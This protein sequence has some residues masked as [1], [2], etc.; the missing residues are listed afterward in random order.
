MAAFL[1]VALFECSDS[2]CCIKET[3]E[4]VATCFSSNEAF[5]SCLSDVFSRIQAFQFLHHLPAAP[6][7]PVRRGVQLSLFDEECASDMAARSYGIKFNSS[8]GARRRLCSMCRMYCSSI[9][10]QGRQQHRLHS[11]A[12]VVADEILNFL[13]EM[14]DLAQIAA[15]IPHQKPLQNGHGMSVLENQDRYVGEFKAGKM[16]GKGQILGCNGDIYCGE[17]HDGLIHGHGVMFYCDG[18]KYEGSFANGQTNGKGTFT[19]G[20]TGS[21]HV[22][23]WKD[24]QKHGEGH[25]QCVCDFRT[26]SSVVFAG[27]NFKGSYNNGKR[28]GIGTTTFFNGDVSTSIWKSGCSIEYDN[29]QRSVLASSG[30]NL[31]LSCV[32]NHSTSS[33]GFGDVGSTIAAV[34]AHERPLFQHCIKNALQQTL[35]FEVVSDALGYPCKFT[36]SGSGCAPEFLFCPHLQVFGDAFT[37]WTGSIQ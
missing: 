26:N 3:S 2:K 21:I 19:C 4:T 16:D 36:C 13:D 33:Q 22:G 34:F 29:F 12:P 7:H 5:A 11:A 24:A 17:F 35:R 20:T 18:S 10:Y 27:D 37:L 31:C 28:N 32:L 9:C 6:E 30:D 8:G 15:A 14:F 25:H 1:S 23:E